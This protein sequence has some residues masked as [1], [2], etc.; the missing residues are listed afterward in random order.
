MKGKTMYS[1]QDL[2]SEIEAKVDNMRS[3]RVPILNP[4]SIAQDILNDHADVGEDF[5]VRETTRETIR[6]EV[7]NYLKRLDPTAEKPDLTKLGPEELRAMAEGCSK[8]A[9]E[10]R[11]YLAARRAARESLPLSD[12]AAVEDQP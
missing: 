7:L 12:E 5:Y 8:H 10:L 4:D 2:I 11:Q 3:L 6:K 1:M 9:E